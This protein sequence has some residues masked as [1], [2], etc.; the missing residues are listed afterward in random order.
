MSRA[1]Y[2]YVEHSIRHESSGG[3]TYELFCTAPDCEEESARQEGQEASQDWALRHAGLNPGHDLFRRVFTA[4]A[5]V[6]RVE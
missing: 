3:V 5:R 1:V 2:R 4:H 6:S